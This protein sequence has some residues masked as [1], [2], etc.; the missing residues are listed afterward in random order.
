MGLS[1]EDR[2]RIQAALTAA[3]A[4][5]QVHIAA[6]VV[7]VSDRYALF[8]L[9]W[10][11]AIALVVGGALA[12][13]QSHLSL[14]MGFAAESASFVV[15]S[16]LFDWFPLRLRLVP[17][18]IRHFHARVLA[19][20]EFAARILASHE[21]KGGILFFVSLGERYAEIIADRD[22]HARVGTDTWNKIVADFVTA[23]K[24]GRIPDGIVSAIAACE[25]V[26]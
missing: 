9:V 21:L 2:Q 26:L 6:S 4:R 1:H 17:K 24:Q 25:G 3:E 12:I 20:R 16:V 15:F 13:F 23:A 19:H 10:A 14:R 5:C 18:R 11:A 8:P 22:I 7:P